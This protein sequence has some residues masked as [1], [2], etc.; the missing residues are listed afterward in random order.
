LDCE[1]TVEQLLRISLVCLSN[2]AGCQCSLSAPFKPLFKPPCKPLPSGRS[3]TAAICHFI[4]TAV[5]TA[6][7]VA[8]VVAAV[9][10]VE[11]KHMSLV[12]LLKPPTHPTDTV[13]EKL[14]LRL[15]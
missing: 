2:T 11:V 4:V 8:A 5:A 6:A 14:G 7:A 12:G 15:G 9:G 3:N 13:V 1:W 10:R